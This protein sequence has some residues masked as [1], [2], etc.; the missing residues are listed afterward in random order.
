[1]SMLAEW[2]ASNRI[3]LGVLAAS[4]LVLGATAAQ[5]R[6]VE[7][8]PGAP[9][10]R[11]AATM[12]RVVPRTAAH[13]DAAILAAVARDP[14]RADRRRPPGRYR[15]PG[16]APPPA[17]AA[18]PVAPA[19][20]VYNIRLLGTVVLPDGSGLAALA[21]QTGESRIVKTGQS[22]EGFRVTRVNNGSATL[23][24]SD[25]TLVLRTPAAG[26]AQ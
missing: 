26:G 7:P 3:A 5:A 18:I 14:F 8:L 22:F 21:G 12:P 25:T 16:E 23:R 9:A 1:M 4:L 10:P 20:P 2:T 6:R 11:R 24:G 19:A 15:P 17:A 13:S